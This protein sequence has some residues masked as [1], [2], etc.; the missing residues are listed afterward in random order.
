MLSGNAGD[1]GPTPVALEDA[2]G[3]SGGTDAGAGL[4]EAGDDVG[5]GLFNLGGLV[6]GSPGFW[7]CTGGGTLLT[8]GGS[9]WDC[10]GNGNGGGGG[11]TAYGTAAGIGVAVVPNAPA[12]G[13]SPS[14][15][16]CVG[17]AVPGISMSPSY[18]PP[19][20]PRSEVAG[21]AGDGNGT[22]AFTI[23]R[24]T[25]EHVTSTKQMYPGPRLYVPVKLLFV[26]AVIS[27]PLHSALN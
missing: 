26:T 15:R 23:K 18:T 11:L 12:K 22:N 14:R 25:P 6:D 21:T 20:P 19:S 2:G 24:T 10:W 1:P 5:D 13:A 4:V 7:N 27:F 3:C 9:G 16:D 17:P 8:I